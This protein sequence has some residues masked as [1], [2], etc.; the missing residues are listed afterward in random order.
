MGVTLSIYPFVLCC[1]VLCSTWLCVFFFS[2]CGSEGRGD[3]K[4][5][6]VAPVGL[7]GR[8]RCV[9]SFPHV[10]NAAWT[11]TIKY[12][13]FFFYSAG[14]MK[15]ETR[16]RWTDRSSSCVP[17]HR[18]ALPFSLPEVGVFLFCTCIL[19]SRDG[20]LATFLFLTQPKLT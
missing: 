20:S 1:A 16:D 4:C 5:V 11:N 19:C 7:W 17:P 3:R 18:S 8:E 15:S 10:E 14:W 2:A 9:G 13:S 12:M 6:L